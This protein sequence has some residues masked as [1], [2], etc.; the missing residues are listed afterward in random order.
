MHVVNMASVAVYRRNI[1]NIFMK[2]F[3]EN[4]IFYDKRNQQF[5]VKKNFQKI[6]VTFLYLLCLNSYKT[7]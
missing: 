4:T 1:K 2:Y 5:A 3:Y 6:V 7:N